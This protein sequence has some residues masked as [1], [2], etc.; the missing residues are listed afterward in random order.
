MKPE[1]PNLCSPIKIGNVTF[2][3][4]M[5]SAPMGA[6]E[7]TADHC[8]APRSQGFYEL[9]A[10]GGA[11]AVIISELCVHPPTDG[12][13]M[14]H[15]D[16]AV[17][18]SML[19][20]TFAADAIRRHGAVAGI[21]LSHAGH[22]GRPHLPTGAG[23]P[24]LFG[25]V[26]CTLSNGLKVKALTKT[27]IED[28]IEGYG[29][30]AALVKRAGFEMVMVHGGHG[31]LI[32]QFM[33]P[34]FNKREDE[35][36]GSFENRMRLALQALAGI[37]SAVGAGFPVEFRMSANEYIK[38]GY[39][40][41]EGCRIAK[42]VEASADIIHV[43]AG[44]HE[45]SFYN[46]FPSMFSEH[47]CNVGLAEE[48]K[49]HVRKPVAT[50]GA[51]SDPKQME[52]ILVSGKA[53]II[54]MARQMLADPEFARKTAAGQGDDTVKCIRCLTCM[55]ERRVTQTRR[56][57]VEPRIGR[58]L[59]GMEI[60]PALKKKKVLVAGGGPGGMK[61]ALTAAL[62]GHK[63]I[64]CE[65]TDEL[66]GILKC[67]A[68]IPFKYDMYRLGLSLARLAAKEGVEIRLKTEVD[69]AYAEKEGADAL[70]VAVGSE[71][72]LPALPGINGGNVII[73]NDYHKEKDKVG[74]TVAVLGGGLAG[75]ECAVHLA[76]CGKTVHL[77]EMT[78]DLAP[79]SN[80][81]HRPALLNEI[82]KAGV[83]VHTG[84]KG[85]GVTPEGL[86]YS[87]NGN[88]LIIKCETVICAVG[89]RSCR[90]TAEK[91]HFSAPYV[92][93]IGDCVK[94]A[95]IMTAIY[96]GHHAALD[97]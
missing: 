10:K 73:V 91:L 39:E 79:D 48:I 40:T 54:Y 80:Y 37:R 75:C 31:W 21:E 29:K 87:D 44:H 92:R 63:V 50:L 68:A 23:A 38:G 76:N 36:G 82:A 30:T 34:F 62:R 18:G 3:N 77:I 71:P 11:A 88:E 58:E 17:A 13:H 14:L 69:A 15:I 4:R 95:N 53:D 59:E 51:L 57:S 64:L 70:I 66:G 32:N 8:F 49:K 96:Q 74:N 97:I 26:D 16:P 27:Q 94:P 93:E 12:T 9:R 56:C 28:I 6:T 61:A 33:S 65:K 72:I 55:A 86:L 83:V 2:R 45:L 1:Y 35:Y 52:D 46:M 7:V 60:I 41:D 42:A 78:N 43:S 85:T 81:L 24:P 90:D 84:K 89:Q 47:G 5:F 20:L 19:S 22:I 67:E 25:P